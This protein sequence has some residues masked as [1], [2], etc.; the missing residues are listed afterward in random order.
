MLPKINEV[1]LE[2]QSGRLKV[3]LPIQRN[4]FLFALF[5]LCLLIWIGMSLVIISFLVQDVILSGERF[6]FWLTVMLIVWLV[7]WYAV[8]RILW[9]RWQYYTADREILFIDKEQLIVRR[10][11]SI[12]GITTAYDFKHISPFYRSEKHNC[13]AFDYGYQN[14]YFGHT[15]LDET[16]NRLITYL[17]GRYFPNMEDD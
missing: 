15:L 6:A 9:G 4:W 2:Q 14:V 10:P 11:V 13:L 5:S 8:G 3:V 1:M 12:L 17:N 7:V 16:A